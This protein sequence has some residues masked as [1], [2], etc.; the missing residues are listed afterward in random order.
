MH[1]GP[2]PGPRPGPDPIPIP[3]PVPD[4]DPG[5]SWGASFWN[6]ARS[7]LGTHSG[8]PALLCRSTLISAAQAGWPLI[9]WQLGRTSVGVAMICACRFFDV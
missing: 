1:P 6:A 5:L 8:A 7:I 4:P 2:G 9:F 3:D